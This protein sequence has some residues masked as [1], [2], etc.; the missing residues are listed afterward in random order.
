M[1]AGALTVLD[2]MGLV[3]QNERSY[4]LTTNR[5]QWLQLSGKTDS[6]AM[7]PTG[8]Q[9]RVK[10]T[11]QYNA[12]IHKGML[13]IAGAS[14][15]QANSQTAPTSNMFKTT[16]RVIN[17]ISSIY[18]LVEFDCVDSTG[19][20]VTVADFNLHFWEGATNMA[21][22]LS[23]CSYGKAPFTKLYTLTLSVKL[24]CSGTTH[25]S[26]QYFDSKACDANNLMLIAAE[27]DW[28]VLNVLKINHRRYRHHILVMPQ[29]TKAG[30]G[31]SGTAVVGMATDYQLYLHEVGHN[32]FL[33]HSATSETCDH[34]DF[35]SAMGYCC[36]QRCFNAPHNWQMG[37]SSAL[38]TLDSDSLR[39]GVTHYVSLPS[40]I[41]TSTNF[42]VVT[43]D[44]SDEPHAFFLSYRMGT[45]PYD[46]PLD[47]GLDG[48][49]VHQFDA[50]D[51]STRTDSYLMSVL[52]SSRRGA[53]S[54]VDVGGLFG[55]SGSGL[56]VRLVDA[57]ADNCT[58]ALCRAMS[59]T[60]DSLAACTDGKIN[61]A[62]RVPD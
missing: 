8:T 9:I 45:A 42:V 26:G 16:S 33:G 7:F 61:G 40:Q 20:A 60:E 43:T 27:A 25:D 17:D 47:G 41:T 19:P 39:P 10:A 12:D 34:C 5:G 24:P 32:W 4:F 14:S 1:P 23:T 3:G 11:E 57:D 38:E 50:Q 48:V 15:L 21:G 37:W 51:Q 54:W 31:W 59:S 18:M 55:T 49:L 35:S 52:S 62:W 6:L 53:T 44:W 2:T 29:T 36:T 30:C 22:Y 56:V 28:Y 58:I 13:V 46:V